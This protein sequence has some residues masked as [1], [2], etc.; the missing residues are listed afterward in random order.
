MLLYIDDEKVNFS[1]SDLEN[2]YINKGRE[3]KVYQYRNEA[4]KI[5]TDELKYRKKLTESEVIKM[6]SILTDR[7]LLPKRPIYNESK[8]FIGYTT[9][10]KIEAPKE[11]IGLMKFKDLISDLELIKNDIDI[12]SKN[13]IE[14]DDLNCGSLLM[15]QSNLFIGDPGAY[16][17][18]N[19]SD[20]S[21]L[22]NYNVKKMNY[23]FTRMI[24]LEYLKL[25]KKEKE[26]LKEYFSI[27]SEFFIDKIDKENIKSNQSTN[28][29]LKK[30]LLK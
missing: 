2:R 4:L 26:V 21:D 11:R 12:I 20:T 17:I 13:N 1:K 9:S 8:E 6:S 15:T 23:Y 22:Y 5:Y 30:I 19:S 10:F 24:F 7:I 14:L 27:D 25:T 29:T 18:S 3:G 28:A 16:T